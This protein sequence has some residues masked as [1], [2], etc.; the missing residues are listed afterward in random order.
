M[1][2]LISLLI[3]IVMVGCEIGVRPCY[4]VDEPVK[5]CEAVPTPPDWVEPFIADYCDEGC[6]Y[7]VNYINGQ[8]CEKAWCYDYYYCEW[9]YMGEL[10]Y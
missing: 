8:S 10:C 6:C 1:K 4:P 9:Q 2:K 7:R 3:L 5:L